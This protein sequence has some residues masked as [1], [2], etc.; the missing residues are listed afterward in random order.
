MS[1]TTPDVSPVN[2]VSQAAQ[3]LFAALQDLAKEQI[4]ALPSN[5]QETLKQTV[6]SVEKVVTDLQTNV[7]HVTE[8]GK[9]QIKDF[10][11]RLAQAWEVLFAP[12]PVST[13]EDS[14]SESA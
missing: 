5:V 4:A 11:T 1:E 14:P 3:E 7:A 9:E 10:E 2:R 13:S 6:A 8:Q 12:K